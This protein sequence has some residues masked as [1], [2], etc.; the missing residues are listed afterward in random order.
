MDDF[1]ESEYDRILEQQIAQYR[2]DSL[3]IVSYLEEDNLQA[4][5]DEWGIFY[6]IEDAGSTSKPDAES[7]ISIEYKGYLLDGTVFDQTIAEKPVWLSLKTVI[8]GWRIGVPMIGQ[9]G[10]ITLYL[11]S[12]FG[13]GGQSLGAI[14]SNSVLIFE[15]Y[16]QDFN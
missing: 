11:P 3:K 9:G 16:L 1:D 7:N 5:I 10:K 13:Y 12:Y 6:R 4:S 8:P 15:I 14:P 2:V